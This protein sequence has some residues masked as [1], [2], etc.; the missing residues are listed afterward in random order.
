VPRHTVTKMDIGT[1]KR[2]R[3]CYVESDGQNPSRIVLRLR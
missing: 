1:G 3:S 2:V